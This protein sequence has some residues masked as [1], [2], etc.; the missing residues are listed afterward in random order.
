MLPAPSIIVEWETGRECGGGRA[1]AC[2]AGLNRQMWEERAAFAAPPELI[3]VF[4]PLEV[5]SS[6]VE[7]AAA[8][9][10]ADRGW[11]GRLDV[12]ASPR[13]L[14]YYQKKN[15]GFAR[16]RGDVAIFIDSDLVAEPGW[17]RALVAPFADPAKSVVVGRTHFETGTLYERA[18]ALFWIFDERIAQDRLRPTRRLVSN[19]IAFRRPLFAALPFPDRPTYRGQCSALG[20]RLNGLGIVMYEATAARA[21]HPAPAGARAFAARAAHAGGDTAAHGAMEGR[22]GRLEPLREWRR[23]LASVR[24]RIAARSPVLGAGAG[25]RA[26]AL[27]LGALYYSIKAAAYLAGTARRPSRSRLE[28]AGSASAGAAKTRPGSISLCTSSGQRWHIT[29]RRWVSRISLR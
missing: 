27:A 2:L 20:A 22:V 17:L 13:R 21:V 9:A 7:A 15:F 11:P 3:L 8:A 28:G 12:A 16:A 25:T 6:E 24:R 29:A 26:A 18:M 10:G 14:D 4:D 5:D 23:D 19:N 1:E